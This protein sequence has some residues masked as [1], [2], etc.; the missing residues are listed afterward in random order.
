MVVVKVKTKAVISMFFFVTGVAV[1]W[2]LSI[3]GVVTSVLV[4]YLELHASVHKVIVAVNLI[5]GAVVIV[6]SGASEQ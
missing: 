4:S 3:Y 5:A 6:V 1:V 2:T